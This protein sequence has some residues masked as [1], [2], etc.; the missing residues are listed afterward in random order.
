MPPAPSPHDA[1]AL[2]I[3]ELRHAFV[4]PQGGRLPIL[5]V[6]RL[7][8][9]RGQTLVVRGES[10]SGKTT[11]LHLI[12]GILPVQQ[13]SICV[14]GHELRG[15]S[16]AARDRLRARHVG[17]LFQTFH[18]L[19]A[20]TALENVALALRFQGIGTAAARR[21]ARASLDRVGLADRTRHLPPMLSVG[22]QQRVAIARALVGRP[23]LVLCDE[24]TSSL[25]PARAAAC[26]D[27]LDVFCAEQG[28]AL[29]IV[30]HDPRLAA[31][32]TTFYDLGAPVAEGAST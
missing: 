29:V 19:P 1:P 27:L 30:T 7:Q 18:L 28:A 3:A 2:A 26:M 20:L 10:G 8:I 23:T 31:R 16:E 25:D 4:D 21:Q 22:Q 5:D 14:A 12:A 15:S 24:P 6:E 11:L 32:Y 13:G 17:Y 9:E